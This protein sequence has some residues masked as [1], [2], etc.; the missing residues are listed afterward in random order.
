[1]IRPRQLA[2][3]A[4]LGLLGA[5]HTAPNYLPS[6]QHPPRVVTVSRSVALAAVSYRVVLVDTAGP[7]RGSLMALSGAGN[8]DEL[9]TRLGCRMRQARES[10][11]GWQCTVR[12][13]ERIPDWGALLGQLDRAGLMAPPN[14]SLWRA[15]HALSELVC[16]DGTPWEL[17]V[18]SPS[19]DVLVQDSQVCGPTSARRQAYEGQ[20]EAVLDSVLVRAGAS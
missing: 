20:V 18:R 16:T 9:Q 5:S 12:F 3:W 17:A 13:R 19:G 4:C 10:D 11:Y 6:V 7:V 15:E 14:D 1:M 8:R 2:P